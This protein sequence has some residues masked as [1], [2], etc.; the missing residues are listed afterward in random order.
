MF[1][2]IDT[3]TTLSKMSPII[4]TKAILNQWMLACLGLVALTMLILSGCGGP[5]LTLAMAGLPN[6]N[7]D[8][9]GRPS[10]VII[11]RYELRSDSTFK[12]AEMLPLFSDPVVTLGPDLVAFD[13]MTILPGK[14]YTLE[15]EP[16]LETKF[17][18]VMASFRQTA[19]KGPWKVIVPI[20]SEKSSKIAIELN[21]SSLVLIPA[22]KT[23]KW[24]PEDA[25]ANFRETSKPISNQPS[26]SKPTAPANTNGSKPEAPTNTSGSKPEA[27]T[28]TSGSRLESPANSSQSS[29]APVD[30]AALATDEDG[31]TF[32]APVDSGTPTPIDDSWNSMGAG[33]PN[34]EATAITGPSEY[35]DYPPAGEVGL[36]EAEAAGSGTSSTDAT[37]IWM[38]IGQVTNQ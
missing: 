11:H 2:M 8:L 34:Q 21:S 18:G 38:E 6:A 23:K 37:N 27:P 28:N 7:P 22:D 1:K 35:F 10:P 4:G 36:T 20:N 15:Y 16:M 14:A 31:W 13:E 32:L 33:A 30:S 17:V 5:S 9:T 25:V 19:G 24:D 29:Q 3:N 26:G 12:Q